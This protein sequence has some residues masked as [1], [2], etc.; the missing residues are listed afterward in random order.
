MKKTKKWNLH[1]YPLLTIIC[2]LLCVLSSFFVI[3]AHAAEVAS[4]VLADFDGTDFDI[5]QYPLKE[6]DYSLEVKQIAETADNELI[7]Y[8]YQP[9]GDLAGF[10]AKQIRL[11]T[12]INDNISYRDYDMECLDVE[13][14]IGKYKVKDFKVLPDKLRY[15]AIACIFRKWYEDI[16]EPS[17]NDNTISYVPFDM[18]QLWTASTV[19]NDVSYTLTVLDTIEV[20]K[21]RAGYCDYMT[22]T[23]L[24]GNYTVTED[25]TI[26]FSTD[27]KMDKVHEADVTYAVQTL[28]TEFPAMPE[29]E[30]KEHFA[31]VRADETVNAKDGFV[32]WADKYSWS[33][34]EPVDTYIKR[35]KLT[36]EAEKQI[37]EMDWVLHY[38]T[39]NVT[40]NDLTNKYAGPLKIRDTSILR[41]KYEKDGKTYNVGV[42]DNKTTGTGKSDRDYSSD[43]LDWFRAFLKWL[44]D[45]WVWLVPTIVG[46][47]IIIVALIVFSPFMPIIL[48]GIVSVLKAVGHCLQWLLKGLWWLITAPFRLVVHLFS[49]GGE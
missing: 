16:D 34:I 5:T 13:K 6:N 17:G 42:V 3:P 27:I 40:V 41:L 47:I 25:Y 43:P 19:G 48:S 21:H 45:N 18:S 4:G 35:V 49:G 7:V 36:D 11:S 20:T 38:Y 14:S 8:V 12:G 23:I 2:V 37:K 31:T 33:K 28:V 24:G 32:W 1:I 30:W 10:N 9:F 29:Y 39:R 15:Y 44:Q 26:A 46:G 22:S